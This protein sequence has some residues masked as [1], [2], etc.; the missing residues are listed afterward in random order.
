[1]L[2]AKSPSFFWKEKTDRGTDLQQPRNGS[3][4]MMG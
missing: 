3:D 1:M 2:L 4:V